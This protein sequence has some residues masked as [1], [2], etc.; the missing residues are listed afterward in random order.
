MTEDKIISRLNK[1]QGQ[2]E[3]LGRMYEERR[4]CM[5][6]VQQIIAVRSALGAVGKELLTS[7][8]VHCSRTANKEEFEKVLKQLFSMQ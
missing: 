2:I 4:P 5:D 3:G 8:A 7:E 1:I 6:L